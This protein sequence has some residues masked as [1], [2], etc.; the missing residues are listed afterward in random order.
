MIRHIRSP[1]PVPRASRRA[2]TTLDRAHAMSG[3]AQ[4]T[5][6]NF[7][8][9]KVGKAPEDGGSNQCGWGYHGDIIWKLLVCLQMGS[10]PQKWQRCFG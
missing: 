3:G 1:A 7:A 8:W 4:L 10:G 6:V 5:A 2:G 9:G